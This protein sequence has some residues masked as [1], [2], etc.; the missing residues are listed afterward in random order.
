MKHATPASTLPVYDRAIAQ[1]PHLR[2]IPDAKTFC[3]QL[4]RF[5][6]LPTITV[7]EYTQIAIVANGGEWRKS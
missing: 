2:T 3:R 5:V 4:C 6:A 1:Y 7:A